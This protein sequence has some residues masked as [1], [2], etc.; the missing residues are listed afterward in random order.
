MNVSIT[1]KLALAL[2]DAS[3]V[4]ATAVQYFNSIHL[5]FPVLSESSFYDRLPAV[6]SQPCAEFSLL[7][8]SMALAITV[9]PE[10]ETMKS[11]SSLYMLVKSSIAIVEAADIHCMQVVQARLLV[12][13]FEVGH[14]IEPAAFMSLATTARAAA[15]IGLN[16]GLDIGSGDDDVAKTEEGL[17][18]W[19]GIVMVDR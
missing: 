2:G 6:F 15:A 8:L 10:K 11:F 13:L 5:W 14:G 3:A 1:E 7:C 12:A 17:R 9:P 18:V 4:R 19:W 16:K